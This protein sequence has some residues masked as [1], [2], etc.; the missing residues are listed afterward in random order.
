MYNINTTYA[1]T[2]HRAYVHID[3]CKITWML[4]RLVKIQS[5]HPRRDVNYAI[6]SPIYI[7]ISLQFTPASQDY[8]GTAPQTWGAH[9]ALELLPHMA[10]RRDPNLGDPRYLRQPRDVRQVMSTYS[11]SPIH[12]QV[13]DFIDSAKRCHEYLYSSPKWISRCRVWFYLG[14]TLSMIQLLN[15]QCRSDWS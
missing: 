12:Q 6:E 10:D 11:L 1:N 8:M 5:S 7:W 2:D 3:K 4:L 13:P 14:W 15:F 9:L